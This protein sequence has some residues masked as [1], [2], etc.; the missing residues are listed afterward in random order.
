MGLVDVVQQLMGPLSRRVSLLLGR[1]VVELSDDT[2]GL[3]VLQASLLPREV[4]GQLERFQQYGFSSRPK[5]GAECLV[6]FLG[7][8]RDHGIVV[9]V[10]D[11]RDRER[12]LAE[13]DSCLWAPGGAR[14][15]VRANGDVEIVSPSKVKLTVSRAEVSGELAVGGNVSSSGQVSDAVGTM[16]AMR[17]TFNLHTH[18]EHDGGSTGP[19]VPPMT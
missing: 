4:R 6:V 15:F 9:A 1:G 14:V 12:G 19:P 10:D 2:H 16:A 18:P 5:K 8:N 3:Q 17:Q 11:R 7:G 13:G